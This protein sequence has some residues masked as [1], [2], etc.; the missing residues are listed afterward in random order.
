MPTFDTPPAPGSDFTA[1]RTMVG[2]VGNDTLMGGA[3]NDSLYGAAGDDVMDGGVGIDTAV[4]VAPRSGYVVTRSAGTNSLGVTSG[5]EGRDALANIE[6]LRFSDVGLA[7]DTGIGQA[8]GQCAL[9]I[10]AVL[11][12]ASL[13]QKKPLVGAVLDLIDQG[14]TLQ[15]LSG[16]VMRLDI[17]G[18]LANG[19]NAGATTTQ[20]AIY[21]LTTVN[22]AAP[23]AATLTTAVAALNTEYDDAHGQGNFLWQLAESAANQTQVG[24]AGLAG[25]GLEYMWA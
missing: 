3:G 20:V 16:A 5:A 21:L 11:G 6:R 4:F 12:Q 13:S 15:Q 1:P 2:G 23:D 7:L 17:W 8:G 22:R 18:L 14:F 10:G 9:L 19:G 25:T 24:L